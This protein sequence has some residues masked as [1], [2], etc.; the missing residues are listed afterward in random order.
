MGMRGIRKLSGVTALNPTILGGSERKVHHIGTET[1]I[2]LLQ[3]A[4]SEEEYWSMDGSLN[5]PSRVKE[6]GPTGCKLL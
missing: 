4:D 5:Q 6:D 1:R 3:E 2:K